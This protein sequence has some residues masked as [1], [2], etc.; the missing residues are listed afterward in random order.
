M[1]LKHHKHKKYLHEKV[2]GG[3]NTWGIF[4]RAVIPQHS[5]IEHFQLDCV[6]I[7]YFSRQRLWQ[8]PTE[9]FHYT[10]PNQK[11]FFKRMKI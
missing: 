4:G 1:I 2:N 10:A 5:V 11:T 7:Q 3:G 6:S 8:S 9:S